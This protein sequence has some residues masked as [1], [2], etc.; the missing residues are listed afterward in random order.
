MINQPDEQ[1]R[2]EA[3]RL[4]HPSLSHMHPMDDVQPVIR[5]T[6]NIPKMREKRVLVGGSKELEN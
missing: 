6:R 2:A 4:G 5:R 1:T 3:G